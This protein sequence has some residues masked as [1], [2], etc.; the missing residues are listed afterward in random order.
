MAS[1]ARNALRGGLQ[2]FQ[3]ILPF[4]LGELDSLQLP[5]P[6]AMPEVDIGAAPPPIGGP[7][8]PLGPGGEL[9]GFADLDLP[10]ELEILARIMGWGRT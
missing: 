2:G 1:R 6:Q 5:G 8:G 9:T 7:Q 3:D 10:P 4:L